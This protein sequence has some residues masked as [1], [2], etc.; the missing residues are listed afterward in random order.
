MCNIVSQV[1]AE[2]AAYLASDESPFV[3]GPLK[4]R[5]AGQLSDAHSTRL[6]LVTVFAL[7]PAGGNGSPQ[8][9]KRQKHS[10]EI[11][12]GAMFGLESLPQGLALMRA[13]VSRV[14]NPQL[15]KHY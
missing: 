7:F 3:A 12:G 8:T 2:P 10:F 15:L 9:V 4:N 14:S 1:S 5:F 6:H 11:R 13:L